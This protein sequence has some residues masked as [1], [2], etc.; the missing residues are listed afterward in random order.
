M[1]NDFVSVTPEADT[2]AVFLTIDPGLALGFVFTTSW[3]TALCP[4]VRLL[5]VQ[6][7]IPV[8]PAAGSLQVHPPAG[9]NRRKVADTADPAAGIVSLTTGFGASLGPLFVAVIV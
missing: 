3:N 7:T 9:V 6:L 1:F 5:I 4:E 8:P 2:E